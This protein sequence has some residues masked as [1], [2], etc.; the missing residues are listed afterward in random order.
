MYVLHM[1]VENAWLSHRACSIPGDVV[2]HGLQ[3]LHFARHQVRQMISWISHTGSLSFCI[4]YT[5]FQVT[6]K[7]SFVGFNSTLLILNCGKYMLNFMDSS[8]SLDW[9]CARTQSSQHKSKNHYLAKRQ[10]WKHHLTTLISNSMFA[11][12]FLLLCLF[13]LTGSHK[14][15][16]CSEYNYIKQ[17]STF[18]LTVIFLADYSRKAPIDWS[19]RSI[20]S[21]CTSS[22]SWWQW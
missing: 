5:V 12:R 9:A 3:G 16:F 20:K 15:N 10:F 13:L 4:Q 2:A 8:C 22:K 14:P 21:K 19:C 17:H 6:C 18:L 1:S 11:I 7:S